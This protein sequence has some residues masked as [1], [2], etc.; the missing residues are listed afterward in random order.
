L[1][2]YLRPK[3]DWHYRYSSYETAMMIET[4]LTAYC[5]WMKTGNWSFSEAGIWDHMI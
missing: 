3:K 2:C 1:I 4:W 5:K